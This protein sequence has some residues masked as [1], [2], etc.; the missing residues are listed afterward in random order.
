MR[1]ARLV[2][3]VNRLVG[4][5]AVI[6]VFGTEVGSSLQRGHRVLDVVVLLKPGL[7]PLQDVDGLFDRR[8][9]HINLLEAPRQR[10]VFLEDTAVLGEGGCADALER[11]RA[12]ARL[13]QVGRIKRSTRG[14]TGPDQGVDF[15][16]EQHRVGLVLER[17]QHAL[18]PL[19]KI[20]AVLGAGQQR[21]HVERIDH[22]VG[23]NFRHIFLRDAPGQAFGNRRLAHTSLAHQQGVV[24]AATTQDLDHPLHLILAPDQRID[25]AVLGELVEVL[26]VLL[27]RRGLLVL[28]G[29][30][31][32]GL[33]RGFA[34]LG[35]LGWIAFL[36]AVR[37][38]VHHVQP[39]HALLMKVVHRV[40]I[41]FA[42][43]GDQYVGAGDFLFAAAG[44]LHMHDG[45][46]DHP[47]K[48]K[49]WLGVDIVRAR[50]LGRVV[51]D[52]VGQR[53]TQIVNIGRTGL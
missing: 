19:L 20:T 4:Q 33:R 22:R 13:E 28:F 16:D 41:F 5:M 2:D 8:F 52:E 43:N 45:A 49:G 18:E 34:R 50:H 38:E 3:D 35:G 44:G 46:L 11:T 32:F 37:D 53:F 39:G 29:G 51:L 47:L 26:R 42:K 10:C 12:Q 48:A 23:Q 21:A 25:L 31:V 24:L 15:V 6:D 17:L 1:R 9:H 27:Q 36:D 7:E 14:R 40:R 30:A